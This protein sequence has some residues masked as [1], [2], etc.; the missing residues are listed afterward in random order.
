MIDPMLEDAANALKDR[1]EELRTVLAAQGEEGEETQLAEE[2]VCLAVRF[3]TALFLPAWVES[4][5]KYDQGLT[6]CL[7][8]YV[9]E[10]LDILPEGTQYFKSVK[11]RQKELENHITDKPGA[12]LHSIKL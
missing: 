5:Y 1:T 12:V 9:K 3:A 10:A 7:R 2:S 6:N 4:G 8:A 11:D